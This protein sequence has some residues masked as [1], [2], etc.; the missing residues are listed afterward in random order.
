[1]LAVN[2]KPFSDSVKGISRKDEL[3]ILNTTPENKKLEDT[4]SGP[5]GVNNQGLNA[6][7]I[8]IE[9]SK[10]N[11]LNIQTDKSKL[12][13]PVKFP[14]IH[15]KSNEEWKNYD[16]ESRGDVAYYNFD[17]NVPLMAYSMNK[18]L[19]Y[20]NRG[21]E[22][23]HIQRRKLIALQRKR[24]ADLE[25]MREEKE[26]ML[27]DEYEAPHDPSI[28]SAAMIKLKKQYEAKEKE[29]RLDRDNIVVRTI[30]ISEGPDS[31]GRRLYMFYL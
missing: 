3:N 11:D 2:S 25:R 1:M 21:D 18:K 5:K 16:P 15:R 8:N 27:D 4:T 31:K 20:T 10:S 9:D 19:K 17:S 30:F 12:K 28:S 24:R 7:N 14:P 13:M 22:K 6:S 29:K 23:S 26:K